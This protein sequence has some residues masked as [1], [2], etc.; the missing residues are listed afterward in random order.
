MQ[1][2]EPLVARIAAG[3]INVLVLGE[4]GV[5]KEVMARTIHARSP[6]ATAPLVCLNCAA[7][8]E[9]LLESELF[10]HE[11]GAFTGAV[12][13]KEGLLESAK[14]GTVFLDEV[15]EMPLALQA[16]LL[17]VLEQR[18]V[19]RVGALRPRPIDVRFVSAT[20]RDLEA[21]SLAGRFR[22]DLYFRLN[23]IAIEIPP[24]RARREEIDALARA[25]VTQASREAGRAPPLLAPDALAQLGRYSWPGNIRE[26]KNVME[27]AVLLC[28]GGEITVGHLRLGRGAELASKPPGPG[29]AP[30]PSFADKD[31][32]WRTER[33][34]IMAALD[35]CV[36]NQTYAAKI[37]GISRRTLVTWMT[38]Y[39]VPRP[40]KRP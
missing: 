27:R 12:Q 4:T 2:L 25:F 34:R 10:G 15:G 40:R 17:R 28:E 8:S 30:A 39:E 33:A 5:G 18:E 32:E 3:T 23:G 19:L 36:G 37:L 38:E 13:A 9:A 35:Q 29:D 21:E 31:D 26:L 7:L 6:R 16:K 20:N 11:K 22:Q 14:G 1:A 24:L